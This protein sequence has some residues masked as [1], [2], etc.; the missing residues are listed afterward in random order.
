M[1]ERP[2][3]ILNRGISVAAGPIWAFSLYL[4]FAGHNQPGGGFAGGLVAGVFIAVIAGA[5]GVEAVRRFIPLRSTAL[6][7]IGITV[8]ALT[9][10]APML[11][12]SA[13]LESGYVQFDLPLLG[14]L[15]MVSAL[16]FD[17][18]VY[19]V[20]VGVSLSLIRALGSSLGE[21]GDS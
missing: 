21:R 19:L 15:K 10:F 4:L 18:G 7:G 3:P 12:G 17:I 1:I 14:R 2:S 9:G 5:G 13:F 8:A 6:M 20:V 11:A 16:G